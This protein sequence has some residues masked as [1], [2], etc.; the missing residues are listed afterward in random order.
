MKAPRVA[1]ITAI[2][3]LTEEGGTADEL[4]SDGSLEVKP[5]AVS[6]ADI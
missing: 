1:P 2:Q 4:A 3:V 5:L 6:R